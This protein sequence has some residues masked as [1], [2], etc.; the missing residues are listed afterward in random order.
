L[1]S[2]PYLKGNECRHVFFSICENPERT[3]GI[4]AIIFRTDFNKYLLSLGDST[5][6]AWAW[7]SADYYRPVEQFRYDVCFQGQDGSAGLTRPACKSV[8]ESSLLSK[9]VINEKF[10]G[11]Y[12][13]Y[14]P[15][16]AI[17]LKEEYLDSLFESRLSLCP[18]SFSN[19]VVRYRFYEA[20]AAGRVPVLIGDNCILALEDRID[21]SKCSIRIAETDVNETGAILKDWLSKHSDE[22]IIEMGNYGHGMWLDWL[23]D[24]DWDYNWSRIVKEKLN[25]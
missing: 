9:I 10:Y 14:E 7:G 21:Y 1:R 25:G 19:K 18:C 11:N 20:M 2:L 13:V 5:T 12:E 16:K 15:E 3:V 4:P 6:I 24:D 22:E 23:N 17:R 8:Q